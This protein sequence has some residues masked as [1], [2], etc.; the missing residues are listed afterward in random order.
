MRRAAIFPFLGPAL[1]LYLFADVAASRGELDVLGYAI[2]VLATLLS[3]AVLVRSARSEEAAPRRAA[4]IGLCSAVALLPL[5]SIEPL[6]LSVDI[7]QALSLCLLGVLLLDLALTTPDALLAPFYRRALRILVPAL[8]L[9]SALLSAL[10]LGPT[11]APFGSPWLIPAA[12]AHTGTSFAALAVALALGLRLARRRFGSSPE[13]LAANAWA[14]LGLLPS[15]VLSLLLGAQGLW[16]F[17]ASPLLFRV[18]GALSSGFLYVGHRLLCDPKRQL[19]AGPTTRDFV[20]TSVTLGLVAWAVVVYRAYIP[21]TA[22]AL[23]LWTFANLLVALGLLSTLRPLCRYLLAP[24]RGALLDQLE[25]LQHAFGCVHTLEALARV[26]LGAFRR[27]SRGTVLPRPLLYG[28]DPAFEARSDA[29]GEARISERALHPAILARLRERPAEIIVRAPLAARIVREPP[30]RPLIEALVELDALCVVP[31]VT[32]GELEGALV[33][34]QGG[35]RS[36]LSLEELAALEQCARSLSAYLAV[37]SAKGRAEARAHSTLLAQTKAAS[38]IEHLED[39]GSRLRKDLE[40]FHAGRALRAQA[41]PLI[42]YSAAMRALVE[43][44]RSFAVHDVPVLF[45]AEA[46]LPVEPLARLLHREAGRSAEPFL[47]VDCA[48]VPAAEAMALLF[49]GKHGDATHVGCLRLAGA[50]TLL[51]LDV[52]ALPLEVQRTLASSLASR[53]AR[54]ADTGEGYPLSARLLLHAH[55][56]I[57]TLASAG[58][59]DAGLGERLA[60]VVCRVPPLRERREDIVSLSLLAVDCACRKL[61]RDTLGFESGTL[62]ALAAHDYPG[63]LD[64]LEALVERAVARCTSERVQV[65]DLA[66]GD[67]PSTATRAETLEGTLEDIERRALE[68][69]LLRASG[70]K[71]EAA[72]L[73]GLP[74]TTFLDKLRRHKLDDAARA[75]PSTPP[76]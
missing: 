34:P 51:L 48:A 54:H 46:G 39:E 18:L 71:S 43:Q 6:R 60:A 67:A 12:Y 61:G 58:R 35:R 47:I 59:F 32:D 5:A 25:G 11:L 1:V 52:V 42:A 2:A 7:A 28:F 64:E 14:V 55:T 50:G 72:R 22:L 68:H 19:A 56:D 10:A 74:R 20:A 66:L 15:G 53:T 36:P 31:L 8:A 69:A 24:A 3:C 4:L 40:L 23:G 29:A 9:L 62:E 44:V 27:A 13:A 26:V 63:N 57:E 37:F 73:L 45:L 41:A 76:N 38:R 30:L 70:N 16:H 75:N 21:T 17:S 65:S 33:V 49:G